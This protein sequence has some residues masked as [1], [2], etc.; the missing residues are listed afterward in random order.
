MHNFKFSVS[1]TKESKYSEILLNKNNKCLFSFFS[2]LYTLTFTVKG[3]KVID[4]NISATAFMNLRQLF[5]MYHIDIHICMHILEI[6][7][8]QII[9]INKFGYE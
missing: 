4:K 8:K 7:N 6:N 1:L 2:Y 5:I 9:L 3:F